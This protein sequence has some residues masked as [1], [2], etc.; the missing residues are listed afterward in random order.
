MLNKGFAKRL[1]LCAWLAAAG[2][3]LSGCAAQI[4]E[5]DM[6]DLS[7]R[8]ILPEGKAPDSDGAVARKERMTLY[9]LTEDGAALKPVV[10]EVTVPGG[11]SRA[12]AALEALLAGPQEGERG[13]TWPELGVSR[14]V[15]LLEVSGGV[16]TVDLSAHARTL[17]QQTIY[18]VRL[19]IADT[20]TEFS[21]ISY[22]NVL[23]GGREEGL[24][25]SA[26]LPVGTLTHV[27]DLNVGARYSR[28]HEQRL[29]GEGVTLATTLY[30]PSVDGSLIVPEV[31]NIAYAQVAPIEY[32]YTILGELGKGA[33]LG[34]CAGEIPAPLE[35][36]KEMPEIVRTPDGYLAIAL[37]FDEELEADLSRGGMTLGVYMAMLSDTLM[38]FVPGVEGLKVS[39]GDRDLTALEPDQTPDGR[40]IRFE[41]GLA[42]RN[43]FAGYV[44]AP[45]T[46]YVMREE[47]LGKTQCVI[48]QE[49]ADDPRARLQ[50][51]MSL[52][53][54][55]MFALPEG[56]GAEDILAVFEDEKTIGVNLSGNFGKLLSELS[57]R[58]ER[59]AVYAMV[60][61]L[62]EGAKASKVEFFF[63]GEQVDT[64]AGELEMRGA[65]VRNPG[66]VVD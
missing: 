12:Q 57:P 17:A 33:G 36:I 1:V 42:T 35:Y 48:A 47:G 14:S 3:S 31:R 50:A 30:F 53:A 38:G 10:R 54:E 9:F 49:R 52:N 26:T 39:V 46:L 65:F 19:A 60:N 58:Y 21:E 11:M 24:D 37:C 13:V 43:D 66:M 7:Q 22:V 34:L 61:T 56:L 55:E 20:L 16:A 44:G 23:I 64:L 63:E 6:V 5:R 4:A 27:D 51:L 59:A 8:V 15:R 25:L 62:T 2:L 45:A 40:E 32:L 41:H 29:S 18:A 28:L